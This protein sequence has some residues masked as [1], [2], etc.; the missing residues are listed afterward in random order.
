[1]G[2]SL[3]TAINETSTEI[4]NLLAFCADDLRVE[5]TLVTQV[6]APN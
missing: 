5:S 6:N 3:T 2:K 1:M 4:P